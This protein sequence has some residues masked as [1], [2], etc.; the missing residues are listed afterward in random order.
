MELLNRY[1]AAVRRHLPLKRQDDIIAELRSDLESQLEE[2]EAALGRP[3][4]DAEAAAWLKQ[5]GPPMLV[6]ARYQPQQYLIG[7][8]IFPIYWYVLRMAFGWAT[9]IY[10]IVS[11]VELM[12]GP[13]STET[14]VAAVVRIPGVLMTV[15]AWVTI[16]FAAIEFCARQNPEKYPAITRSSANWSPAA[17]PPVPAAAVGGKKPS[18][19]QAI[20]EVIFSF[21]GLVWLLLLPRHPW[22]L[23]GPG[24]LALQALPFHLAPVWW[25]FYWWVVALNIVQLTWR[26]WSLWSDAWRGPRTVEKIVNGAIGLIPLVVLLTARDHVL[27]MLKA[28]AADVAHNGATLESINL[29]TYRAVLMIFLIAAVG[30]AVEAGRRLVK[31]S[32][33]RAASAR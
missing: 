16:V 30:L 26:S 22:L 20:G 8:A 31:E 6:A 9:A 18:Y 2:R 13:A 12:S 24:A 33:E 29:W 19:A 11:G 10:L 4:T 7:P 32:R 17:L 21:L 1:L 5:I 14:V 28:G 15:A 23:F 27:V 3:M 25:T